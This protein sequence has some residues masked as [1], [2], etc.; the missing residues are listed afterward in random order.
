MDFVELPVDGDS[1]N[2]KWL[3]YDASF[4]YEIGDFDG[5]TFTTDKKAHRGEHGKNYYAAQSF[6]NSPD[7][8]TVMIGWMR[9]S[10][11]IKEKM[12]FNQQMSFPTTMELR[13]T[14]EGVRLLRWPVKEIEKLYSKSHRFENLSVA[15]AAKKLADISAELLDVSVEFEPADLTLSLR[16]LD[17][18]YNATA[19]VFESKSESKGVRMPAPAKDGKVKLRVLID[20]GSIELFANDG[21]AVATSYVLPDPANKSVSITGG[22]TKIIKLLVH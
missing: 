2:K 1:K 19:K 14:D 4:D 10:D 3:L 7:E 21:A 11:F 17:I 13:M 5:K 18:R 15:D 9:G 20:R 12:P 22:E 16:G 8:R 6:N